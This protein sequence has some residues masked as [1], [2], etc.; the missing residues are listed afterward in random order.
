[1]NRLALSAALLAL[2]HAAAATEERPAWSATGFGGV[3]LDN[4][5]DQI[6]L[7]QPHTIRF[8]ES[9]LVGGG[10]TARVWKPHDWID[11]E[12]EVQLVRHFGAQTHWE[13]NAPIVTGRWTYF[14]WN[15]W[16]DTTAAF[17]VGLSFASEKPKREEVNIGTTEQTVAYWMIELDF[18][19][20]VDGWRAIGRVHHR[21]TAFG[22]F[23]EEGGSNALTVGLRRFF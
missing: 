14:P 17:G 11:V 13:V 20:P 2:G 22:T 19:T 5:F 21:S 18:E 7:L 10:V 9:Y 16:L 3:L 6:L 12:V 1:M 4:N 8:E 15:D 23:G